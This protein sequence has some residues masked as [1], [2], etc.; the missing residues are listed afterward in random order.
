[1]QEKIKSFLEKGK[2]R[3]TSAGKKVKILLVA[4]LVVLVA[5]IAVAVVLS[6]NKTYV[7]L[8]TELNQ[9]DMSDIVTYLSDNGVTDYQIKDD[10]TILVPE[11][12]EE[13]LKAQ[14]LMQ[15]YPNSGFAYSTYFDHVGSLTTEAERNQLILYELQDR[16]AAVIRSMEGVKDATVQFTPGEDRT[17]VLDSGNVVEASAYAK[18]TMKDGETVSDTLATGIRNLLTRSLQGLSVENVVIVD[19]YGNTYSGEDGLKDTKDTSA[20]KMQLEQQVN[21]RVRTQVMQVLAPLYGAENVQVSVSSVVDVDRTYTDSVDYTTEDWAQDG[22]TDG[23]GI[24]GSKVYDMPVAVGEGETAGGTAGTTSNAAGTV[25]DLMVSVSINETTAGDVDETTLYPH[26]ARA[27]GIGEDVQQD[28]IHVMVAPFYEETVSQP[29]QEGL[30]V[31][32]WMIYAALGGAGLFV[33]L[34]IVVLLLAKR[35]KKKKAEAEAQL[36]LAEAALQQ[37]VPAPEGADI[38]EMQ[39]EKSVELR[40][41]VRKFAEDNPEIAAQMVKA[42]LKEGDGAE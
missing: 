33:V 25:S 31:E 1:M 10:S 27:A 14:L 26:I 38:M 5:A 36:A 20:L 34:L 13:S 41:D 18:I 40:Q 35:R 32:M 19:S 4:A 30:Q 28:K 16:T 12:Q 22:S 42:W 39:T 29:A 21:N 37:P 15:G 8:F 7:T 11:E 23:E 17:Y 9:S 6:Q 2:Q 3:W 24:I